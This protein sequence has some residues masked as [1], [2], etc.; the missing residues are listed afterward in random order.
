MASK[1]NAHYTASPREI[2]G[3]SKWKKKEER[4]N[5]NNKRINI[6]GNSKYV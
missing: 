4:E 5:N 1:S 6:I 2:E 3:T